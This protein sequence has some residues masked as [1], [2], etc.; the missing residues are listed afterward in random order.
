MVRFAISWIVVGFVASFSMAAEP[1]VAELKV[2]DRVEIQLT[3]R[4]AADYI[5]LVGR[6][7]PIRKFDDGKTPGLGLDARVISVTDDEVTAEYY[8]NATVNESE[9]ILITITATCPLD[10]VTIDTSGSPPSQ[11]T[12]RKTSYEGVK[13][14]AWTA[15]KLVSP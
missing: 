6:P 10:S 8:H 9:P 3:G 7:I 11:L 15:P 1:N 2:N 12:I 14:R 5:R 4:P 13:I